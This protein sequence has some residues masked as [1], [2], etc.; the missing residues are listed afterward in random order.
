MASS[1]KQFARVVTSKKTGEVLSKTIVLDL[2]SANATYKSLKSR[3][4]SD[5]N[6]SIE[7]VDNPSHEDFEKLKDYFTETTKG[8]KDILN[9]FKEK[10]P[11]FINECQR[12]NIITNTEYYETLLNIT[13]IKKSKI[14]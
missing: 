13:E 3:W 6:H 9:V 14:I 10:S 2:S 12:R 7:H 11:D 8:I 1:S 4:G 5:F